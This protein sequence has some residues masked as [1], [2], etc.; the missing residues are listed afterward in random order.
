[1]G[2]ATEKLSAERLKAQAK[3]TGIWQRRFWERAIRDPE[4]FNRHVDYI[5]WNP[6]KR[7]HVERVGECS[8]STVRSTGHLSTELG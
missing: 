3:E 1:M 7:G 8:Y 5:D 6:V 4:D 2:V